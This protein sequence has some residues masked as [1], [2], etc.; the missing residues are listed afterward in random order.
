M[1]LIHTAA[2]TMEFVLL[3]YRYALLTALRMMLLNC[4]REQ[5][6]ETS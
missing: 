6:K 3:A 5:G 4:R 2:A 1:P